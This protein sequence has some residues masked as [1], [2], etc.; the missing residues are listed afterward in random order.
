MIAE[1]ARCML[2]ETNMPR[3]W[4]DAVLIKVYLINRSPT[5]SVHIIKLE[6]EWSG[7]KPDLSHLRIFGFVCYVHIPSE[8]RSKLD[9]S[10]K[11][12]YLWVIP[13][14]ERDIDAI[15]QSQKSLSK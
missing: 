13:L 15:I 12:V 7:R 10:L 2:N 4:G 8:L 9:A 1:I 14:S 6:E 11:N 5:T 3:F